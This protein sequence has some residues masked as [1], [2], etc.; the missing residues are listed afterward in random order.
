MATMENVLVGVFDSAAQ[1]RSAHARLLEQGYGDGEVDFDASPS[2]DQEQGI[3][4][5]V[6][7]MFSGFLMNDDPRR[8][9]YADH[10]G[11][12]GGIVALRGLPQHDEA[13]A[14]SILREHGAVAIDRHGPT[15][16]RAPPAGASA[17]QAEHELAAMASIGP[18][19]YV[20]PNA[21]T[22]WGRFTGRSPASVGQ[23]PD[24]ARPQGELR[25]AIGL[26]FHPVGLP[27]AAPFR[28]T[29]ALVGFACALAAFSRGVREARSGA[30][31][32]TPP[33]S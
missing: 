5:V 15:P 24:P 22:D 23:A 26:L 3:A 28:T 31:G 20:L 17:A 2:V 12:G 6:A 25:D 8:H 7:R 30:P 33:V 1:A 18:R 14:S 21:P 27:A 10:L 32:E 9:A 19:A 29:L 16:P 11:R 13:R 4:G